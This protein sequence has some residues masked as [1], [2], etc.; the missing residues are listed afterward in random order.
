MNITTKTSLVGFLLALSA[1]SAT[2]ATAA[3]TESAQNQSQTTIEGRLTKLTNVL[4]VR[5]EQLPESNR[6]IPDQLIAGAWGNGGGRGFVNAHRWR[7]GWA[8]GGGFYN[9]GGGGGGWINRY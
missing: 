1:L 2:V 5:A 9:Y 4:R 6:E 3:T 8:D 7:N